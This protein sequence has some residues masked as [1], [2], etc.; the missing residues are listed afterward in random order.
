MGNAQSYTYADRQRGAW[1]R[2]SPHNHS[3]SDALRRTQSPTDEYMPE[4]GY[5]PGPR[6]G[7]MPRAASTLSGQNL[8]CSENGNEHMGRHFPDS[9]VM[10]EPIPNSV[11]RTPAQAKALKSQSEDRAKDGRSAALPPAQNAGDGH[12]HFEAKSVKGIHDHVYVHE[13]PRT[14]YPES[15]NR[16]RRIANLP[17]SGQ[18]PL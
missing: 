2:N 12:V 18:V 7:Q 11:S 6:G 10:K 5:T 14:P 1:I 3:G 4:F 15:G 16:A 8:A 13:R 9:R 17:L